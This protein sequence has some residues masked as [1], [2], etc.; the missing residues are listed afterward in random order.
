MLMSPHNG[1]AFFSVLLTQLLNLVE[2]NVTYSCESRTTQS[3]S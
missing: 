1:N 2:S 3:F